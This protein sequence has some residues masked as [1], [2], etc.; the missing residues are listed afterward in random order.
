MVD[1]S[2]SY[3]AHSEF[4]TPGQKLTWLQS[5]PENVKEIV[6][7]IQGLLIHSDF[8]HLYEIAVDQYTSASRQTLPVAKKLEGRTDLASRAPSKRLIATCRDYALFTCSF[9][10]E[11][12]FAARLRCGF[13]NYF[14]SG[15]Y[16]DHWICEYWCTELGK[17]VRIDS[18]LDLIHQTNLQIKFDTCDLPQEK[19]LSANEAWVK[20]ERGGLNPNLFGHG[21]Y[22][23]E[24]MLQIN[25]CRDLLALCNQETSDWDEWRIGYTTHT[26]PQPNEVWSSLARKVDHST[27]LDEYGKLRAQYKNLLIPYWK[28]PSVQ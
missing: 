13:A 24:R 25:L 2:V 20:Y 7:T 6:E 8:L 5:L 16:E 4:T 19:F 15:K 21:E 12:G 10:R 23:G 28:N 11:K 3:L 27:N 22:R 18:Q 9:L 1:G 26:S 17:W 14:I